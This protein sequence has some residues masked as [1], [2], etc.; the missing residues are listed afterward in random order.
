MPLNAP[1][2][3]LIV[4]DEIEIRFLLVD[5]L[6]ELHVDIIEAGDGQE[7][8]NAIQDK[9]IDLILTDLAMPKMN[10]FEFIRRVRALSIKTPIVVLTGHADLLVSNQL[11]AFQ[12]IYF[13]SKPFGNDSLKAEISK[14]LSDLLTAI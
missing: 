8:L 10:G 5:L 4:E 12:P 9:K 1:K 11:K 2:R 13:M 14:H 7:G 3:L 6:K